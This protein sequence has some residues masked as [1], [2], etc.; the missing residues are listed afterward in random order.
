MRTGTVGSATL[1]PSPTAGA[2]FETRRQDGGTHSTPDVVVAAD[3]GATHLR[4]ALVHGT[5]LGPVALRRTADVERDAAAGIA[6]A[7]CRLVKELADADGVRPAALG[8]AVAA[9]VGPLG[10]VRSRP[11]GLPRGDVLRETLESTLSMPV[12]VAND[13]NMAALGELHAGAGRG[14]R[15]FV[16]ITLGTNI[17]GGIVIDGKVV[18]GAHGGAGELGNLQIPAPRGRPGSA[19]AAEIEGDAGGPGYARPARGCALLESVVGGAALARSSTDPAEPSSDGVFVRAAAGDRRA[20]AA[21]RR[22]IEGWALLVANVVALVDPEVIVLSG[23]MVEDA[24][25]VID[26]LRRR[27]A[28]LVGFTP[29]IRIG[30]LGSSAGLI[31]AAIAARELLGAPDAR[32]RSIDPPRSIR[33]PAGAF[34]DTGGKD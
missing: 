23:G 18:V 4:L 27:A 11:F 3:A 30:E 34:A 5:E 8:I 17:G 12:I 20:R 25:G 22:A 6:P 33:G 28:E 31:G 13:A 21:V 14:H 9:D 32:Q 7:L 15:D 2:A 29:D 19:D 1:A 26:D 16:L 10:L 24:A